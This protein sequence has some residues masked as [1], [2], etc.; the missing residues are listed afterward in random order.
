MDMSSWEEKY[1]IQAL[2]DIPAPADLLQQNARL[3]AGGKA[4]DIAMGA[5][6]NAVFLARHGCD[7]TGVDFSA[8]AVAMARMLAAREGLDLRA[9]T[10]DMLAFPFPEDCF[11]LIVNFNFL[12]RSLIPLIRSSLKAGGLLFF[13]TY[14]VEQARFG[15]P[16]NP[17]H[18]LEPNE[19][20]SWFLDCFIIFYHERIDNGRA[21]AS[22]IARKV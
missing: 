10:A 12:E 13:E 5:G 4:L 19:L 6:Q 2:D 14:T 7:V 3:I 15:R 17:A 20:L 8:S 1:K 18:L 21:I 22:L 9:V 16:C 11:D